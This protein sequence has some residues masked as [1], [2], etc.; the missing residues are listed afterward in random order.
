[1][2]RDDAEEFIV[3]VGD[4]EYSSVDNSDLFDG[5]NFNAAGRIA[6]GDESR[7]Y[8]SYGRQERTSLGAI[9]SVDIS[10]PSIQRYLAYTNSF[11]YLGTRYNTFIDDYDE[12]KTLCFIL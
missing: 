11:E 1:M 10:N 4:K 6:Y 9:L 7:S 12:L 3:K 5:Y 8:G 2:L